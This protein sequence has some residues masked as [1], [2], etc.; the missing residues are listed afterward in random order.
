LLLVTLAALLLAPI[1]LGLG[2]WRAGRA[3]WW[4]AAVWVFSTVGFLAT[5]TTKLGDL[6]GF[7]V[8]MAVLAALGTAAATERYAVAATATAEPASRNAALR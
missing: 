2:V 5:E 8:M 3:P 1:V 4:L 6:V 7:G